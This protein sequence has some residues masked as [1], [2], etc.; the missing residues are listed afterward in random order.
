MESERRLSSGDRRPQPLCDPAGADGD[1]AQRG[2]AGT[3]GPGVRGVRGAGGHA[4]GSRYA[5]VEWGGAERLDGADGVVNAPGD[6]AALWPLS[7]SPD[8]GEGGG[9]LW[10]AGGGAG[11]G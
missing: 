6:T 3:A 11:G 1:D 10:G 2:G 9:G 8:A 5:V 7:A 4:D